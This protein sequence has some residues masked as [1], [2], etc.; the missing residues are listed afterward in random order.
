MRAF[1]FSLFV[2]SALIATSGISAQRG[3]G[4]SLDP[5]AVRATNNRFAGIWKLVGRGNPRRE[6]PDRSAGS[7]RQQRWPFR[8]HRVRPGRLHG[9]H[10]CVARPADVCGPATDAGRSARRDGHV[11]LVLGIV[12]GERSH[13]AS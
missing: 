6:R 5:A 13:A 3:G 2:G 12:R 10:D 7:E 1:V 9:R 8:V 4:Q 11:Q